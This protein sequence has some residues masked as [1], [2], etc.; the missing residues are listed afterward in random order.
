M[1][2][3]VRSPYGLGVVDIPLWGQKNSEIELPDMTR[4]VLGQVACV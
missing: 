4:R 1:P 2:L 3:S